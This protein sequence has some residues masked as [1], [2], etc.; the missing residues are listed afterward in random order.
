MED[1]VIRFYFLHGLSY[2]E[3][4]VQL[5]LHHDTYISLK[6]LKR[7]LKTLN[8]FRR[9]E[10]TDLETLVLYLQEELRASGQM[11][12]YKWMHAKCVERGLIVTQETVRMALQVSSYFLSLDIHHKK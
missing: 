11:H 12:G 8:L 3:I 9:K 4:L 1:A 6:T 5:A 2:K 10:K 7:K